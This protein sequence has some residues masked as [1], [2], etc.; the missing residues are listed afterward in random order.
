MWCTL[1]A[2]P[3]NGNISCLHVAVHRCDEGSAGFLRTLLGLKLGLD[4]N[5]QTT[6]SPVAPDP[7]SKLSLLKTFNFSSD[8]AAKKDSFHPGVLDPLDK[9]E[10]MSLF[11]TRT[12][13]ET[14][15][16][17]VMPSWTPLHML[18]AQ[19]QNQKVHTQTA[20]SLAFWCNF[21]WNCQLCNAALHALE[22]NGA[23]HA[24]SGS[25]WCYVLCCLSE[26]VYKSMLSA[27]LSLYCPVGCADGWRL[28]EQWCSSRRT[29]KP[30][31]LPIVYC[32][33]QQQCQSE[34]HW[35][36]MCFWILHPTSCFLRIIF[37]LVEV[38]T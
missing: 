11:E 27:F 32:P 14:A 13:L 23:V 4:V 2:F 25:T 30:G 20:A 29:N 9:E 8:P 6:P 33:P 16:L 34:W 31:S 36:N 18:A 35:W 21:C 19:E 17:P 10:I 5:C 38:N 7:R 24:F 15:L 12:P 3:Q 28:A 22:W 26:C 37:T 1:M